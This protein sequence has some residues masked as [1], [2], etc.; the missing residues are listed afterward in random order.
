MYRISRTSTDPRVEV[1][2]QGKWHG[3]PLD[4]RALVHSLEIELAPNETRL[5]S[6]HEALQAIREELELIEHEKAQLSQTR[7]ALQQHIL[8][9]LRRIGRH[10]A[11]A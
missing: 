5:L 10:V 1:F 11:T 9:I 6:D 7:T 2:A 4:G 3:L 8:S